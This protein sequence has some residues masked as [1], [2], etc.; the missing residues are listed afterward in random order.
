MA[1]GSLMKQ[2]RNTCVG[3][4]GSHVPQMLR[5]HVEN[6]PE[7]HRPAQGEQTTLKCF[8]YPSHATTPLVITYDCTANNAHAL[9]LTT[10]E[11]TRTTL[12]QDSVRGGEK[13][14]KV[15]TCAIPV[16]QCKEHSVHVA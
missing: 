2:S 16:E 1:S 7:L 13:L 11:I 6:I 5:V 9:T 15:V 8:R 4:T 10:E 3:T 12:H 14:V